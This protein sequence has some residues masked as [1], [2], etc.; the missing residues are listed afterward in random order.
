MSSTI[1]GMNSTAEYKTRFLSSW[2]LHCSWGRNTNR[3]IIADVYSVRP[4]ESPEKQERENGNSEGGSYHCMW[5][6]GPQLSNK[7]AF[8]TAEGN[9]GG[10]H[11]TNLRKSNPSIEKTAYIRNGRQEPLGIFMSEQEGK[12]CGCSTEC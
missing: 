5:S 7:V 1:L 8:S 3:Q 4:L 11:A 9:E 2:G 10:N 12:I 6:G